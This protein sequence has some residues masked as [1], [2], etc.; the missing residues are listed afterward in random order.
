MPKYTTTIQ[1][2]SAI[3]GEI[4]VCAHRVVYRYWDAE[5]SITDELAREMEEGAEQRAKE[6]IIEGYIAGELNFYRAEPE[7]EISGWWEIQREVR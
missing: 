1:D 5:N 3:E 6:C 4:T 7:E 2:R